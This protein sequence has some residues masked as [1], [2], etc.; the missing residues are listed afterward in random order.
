MID[1]VENLAIVWASI[2]WL[3]SDL[4][5]GQWDLPTGVPGMDGQG[6]AL[7]PGGLQGTRTGPACVRARAWPAAPREE[8]DGPGE[9][10]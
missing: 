10:G 6:P 2:D 8:R 1:S 4:P 3:C 5:V 7:A 9:R